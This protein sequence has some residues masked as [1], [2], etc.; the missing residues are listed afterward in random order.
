MKTKKK[1][2]TELTAENFRVSLPSI[3]YDD[4]NMK[5]EMALSF[6]IQSKIAVVVRRSLFALLGLSVN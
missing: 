4:E 3:V 2:P 1:K 5:G 6:L